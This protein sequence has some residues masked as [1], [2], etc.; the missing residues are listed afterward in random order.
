MRK[1]ERVTASQF[2]H[3]AV[4]VGDVTPT[5]LEVGQVG[6]GEHL[7]VLLLTTDQKE[8]TVKFKILPHVLGIKAN[9]PRKVSD[10]A[11]QMICRGHFGPTSKISNFIFF[12]LEEISC[13]MGRPGSSA[14]HARLADGAA[15]LGAA[16]RVGGRRQLKHAVRL[17]W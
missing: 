12:I 15:R 16:G 11:G 10:G 6:V 8:G 7:A 1:T 14:A 3:P 17:V 4:V 13:P 2:G 9:A 5:V